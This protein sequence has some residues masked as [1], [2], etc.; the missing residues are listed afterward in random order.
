[1]ASGNVVGGDLS[2]LDRPDGYAG[3]ES[4]RISSLLVMAIP[5]ALDCHD[6]AVL[7]HPNLRE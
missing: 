4:G 5:K 7:E 2:E 1:V 3:A 6:E